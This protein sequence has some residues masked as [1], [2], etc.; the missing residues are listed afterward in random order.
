MQRKVKET[1]TV[2]L[3]VAA[4]RSE[5]MGENTIPKPYMQLGEEIV[6][7]HTIKTFL[8]HPDIDGV[9]VVIR[10][11]H[12][13]LYKKAIEDLTLIP[14]VIGGNS[15][16]ESV[17]IGLESISYLHPK[18]VLV[19]DV[20]RPMASK[21]LISRV[22][23]ALNRHKAVIPALPVNDTIKRVKEGKVADTVPR[24]G[25]V[26]VQ[27][28]QGFDFQ[29]LLMAHRQV[30]GEN[31]TDDSA[32]CE[33]LNIPVTTVA[34]E[35]DN[36]K[37][38]TLEDLRKMEQNMV[39]N[40]ETRVGIGYDVH[41]LTLHDSDTPVSQQIIKICGISI[42]FTHYLAGHSDADVG[43]HALVDAIL[44]A[45]GASDI[46]THFPSNDIKW[47][48]ADSSRFLLH[49]YQLLKNRGGELVN[50]DI[51]IVCERPRISQ[52]RDSMVEHLANILKIDKDRI[53]IKGTT[54]EKLGFEGRGE[55]IS[56]QA[57][58][59]VRLRK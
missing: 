47:Q 6:L 26:I 9:R 33:I 37:I 50:I 8:S 5:R 7:R 35:T 12:H 29:T 51:V 16:Q 15:R 34:G 56:A 14:C 49:A 45:I 39:A 27:T 53:N 40:T 52:H 54:T 36:F 31:L 4:G 23:E 24:E 1:G 55:G 2:A 58:V 44:G 43:L 30:T 19:H 20:A 11:E 21:E 13:P 32:V 59:S 38:T 46:G 28:P 25:T 57:I 18:K 48:G 3:L 22:N 42:P 17:R 41:Q 10:R